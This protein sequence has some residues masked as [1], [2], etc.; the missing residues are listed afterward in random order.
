MVGSDETSRLM[1]GKRA[2]GKHL[3][4]RHLTGTT[5][6]EGVTFA[7]HH[8]GGDDSAKRKSESRPSASARAHYRDVRVLKYDAHDMIRPLSPWKALL[9]EVTREATVVGCS[10][11][12]FSRIAVGFVVSLLVA[13]LSVFR[14][15]SK[16]PDNLLRLST[17]INTGLFFILGPYVSIMIGRWWDVR[18][19]GI[20]G[21]WG[22]VDDLCT[23][24]SGW[25]CSG[26]EPDKAAKALVLRYGLASLALLFKAARGEEDDL[27]DLVSNGLLEPQEA[28]AL[29]PLPSKAQVIWTWQVNFWHRALSTDEATRGGLQCTKIS[30]GPYLEPLVMEKCMGARGGIGLCLA[31]VDTQQPFAYVH[32]LT[33]LADVAILCNAFYSGTVLAADLLDPV[34]P[35]G[36]TL[37]PTIPLYQHLGSTGNCP[38][39]IVAYGW[40]GVFEFVCELVT[41]IAVIVTFPLIYHGLL[42][43]AIMLD[44]PMDQTESTDF[45]AAAYHAYM[46]AENRG[47]FAGVE[48]IDLGKGEASWWRGVR[49]VKA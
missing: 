7:L 14:P 9:N 10:W 44:N 27:D 1:L 33:T 25:F 12:I 29:A 20:G 22:G 11:A 39:A 43:I 32:L 30:N 3:T 23:Y 4:F 18:K 28:E 40:G 42:V 45:P 13:G 19:S 37:D 15:S 17:A 35:E 21:L 34:C 31:Y 47:F 2:H 24:A 48:A 49:G 5:N 8:S 16:A 38:P 36:T 6:V 26:S 46:Q 41:Y